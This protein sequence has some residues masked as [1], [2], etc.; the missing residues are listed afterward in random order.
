MK[1]QLNI[2]FKEAHS[3]FS[4][5]S[6]KDRDTLTN[7]FTYLSKLDVHTLLS[8]ASIEDIKKKIYNKTSQDIVFEF[9]TFLNTRLFINNVTEEMLC[10]LCKNNLRLY[11]AKSVSDTLYKTIVSSEIN[12][13]YFEN[14]RMLLLIYLTR[15]HINN[16]LFLIKERASNE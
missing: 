1:E 13:K 6:K 11:N 2:S 7:F 10:D 14:D 5:Y 16:L 15:L 8:A 4:L 12:D 3:A 9:L